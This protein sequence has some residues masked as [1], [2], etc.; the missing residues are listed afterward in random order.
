MHRRC[1]IHRFGR[2]AVIHLFRAALRRVSIGLG[3]ILCGCT[4]SAPLHRFV[5][6]PAS[7]ASQAITLELHK[8]QRLSFW[9]SL[10]LSFAEEAGVAF[11]ISILPADGAWERVVT[12]DALKPSMTFMSTET[13]LQG[14]ISQSW[15]TARMRCSYGP[16]Q[17]NQSVT[18]SVEPELSGQVVVRRLVLEIKG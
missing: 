16:V 13:V 17:Q 2:P 15:K 3:V 10:D 11:M 12:C 9:N 18:I 1:M 8:G 14:R 6:D 5:F 7:L 4:G